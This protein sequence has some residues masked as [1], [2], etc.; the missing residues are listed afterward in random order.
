MTCRS[1]ILES[2]SYLVRGRAQPEFEIMEVIEHMRKRGTRYA[3]SSIRTH[4]TSRMCANAP[5]NHPVTYDDF[6]RVG[7]GRYRLL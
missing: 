5:N 3:E 6:E 1:E 4:I 7:F 2:V